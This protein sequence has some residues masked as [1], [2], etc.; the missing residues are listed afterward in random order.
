MIPFLLILAFSIWISRNIERER[1]KNPRKAQKLKWVLILVL[2]SFLG[3]RNGVGADFFAYIYDYNKWIPLSYGE[4][5]SNNEPLIKLIAKFCHLFYSSSVTPFFWIIAFVFVAPS[6]C[7]IYKYADQFALAVVI[8]ILCGSYL[9]SCNAARQCMAAAVIFANYD[10]LRRQ[11]LVRYLLLT[12]V[13]TLLHS[14]AITMLPLYF[15]FSPKASL[16]MQ[17]LWMLGTAALLLVSFSLLMDISSEVLGKELEEDVEYFNTAVSAFRVLVFL[18]PCVL[19]LYLKRREKRLP[20]FA[21]FLLFNAILAL[22]TS[23]SAY[24]MRV[25]IYTNIFTCLALPEVLENLTLPPKSVR[26]IMTI[27]LLCYFFY[28]IYGILHSAGLYPYHSV[29]FI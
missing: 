15:V 26:N 4:I 11:R 29:F 5:L 27:M 17:C 9:D 25:C 1:I 14:S 16:K 22:V 19:L 8:F 24:L 2:T 20:T 21:V 7:T 10:N 28:W 18:G 12:A 23:R 3:F 6:I 13:A